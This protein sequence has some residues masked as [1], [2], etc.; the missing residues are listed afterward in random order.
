MTTIDRVRG[1]VPFICIQNVLLQS[2]RFTRVKQ[3]CALGKGFGTA[4]DG[5]QSARSR[6]PDDKARPCTASTRGWLRTYFLF[7][8]SLSFFLS[9]SLSL[10]LRVGW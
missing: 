10:L 2:K 3:A 9:L 5:A 8:P 7:S 4:Q 6:Q 1:S